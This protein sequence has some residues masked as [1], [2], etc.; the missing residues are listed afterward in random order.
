[1]LP[2]QV[3]GGAGEAARNEEDEDEEEEDGG[4]DAHGY[5]SEDSFDE[6][7]LR[8]VVALSVQVPNLAAAV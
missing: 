7:I 3:V 8:H 5:S 2:A 6:D 1:M 4:D